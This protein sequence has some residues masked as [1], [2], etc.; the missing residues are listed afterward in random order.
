MSVATKTIQMEIIWMK[1]EYICDTED[2][3]GKVEFDPLNSSPSSGYNH[4]FYWNH[5]CNKC[6]RHYAFKDIKYPHRYK[7][8]REIDNPTK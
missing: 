2:C 3:D 6:G 1:D 8:E 5:Y 4:L 7:I